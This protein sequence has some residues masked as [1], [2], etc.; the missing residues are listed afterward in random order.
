MGA[1]TTRRT[2]RR[3]R[4]GGIQDRRRQALRPEAFHS[5]NGEHWDGRPSKGED[6]EFAA[7]GENRKL[8]Q[9]RAK[10]EEPLQSGGSVWVDQSSRRSS[11]DQAPQA[12]QSLDGFHSQRDRQKHDDYGKTG[13]MGG[14][15]A[16]GG[17]NRR[18]SGQIDP[19]ER[20][21]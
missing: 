10:Y 14:L 19:E 9:L 21:K 18:F 4:K 6:Q 12:R 5:W 7:F 13:N 16:P 1:K 2:D 11:P 3:V 17:P 15:I 20:R 8:S